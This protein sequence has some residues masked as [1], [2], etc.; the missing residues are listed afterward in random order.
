MV[1]ARRRRDRSEV[2]ATHRSQIFQALKPASRAVLLQEARLTLAQARVPIS[3]PTQSATPQPESGVQ[4]KEGR[5]DA[6]QAA[7]KAPFDVVVVRQ[8]VRAGNMWRRANRG[9]AP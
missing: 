6:P 1:L 5:Q 4:N 2:D 3:L 9:P 8:L 7:L